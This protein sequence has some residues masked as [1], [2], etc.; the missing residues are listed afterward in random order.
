MKNARA[1]APP[2]L[3]VLRPRAPHLTA[4]ARAPPRGAPGLVSLSR[5]AERARAE[6][7]DPYSSA[8]DAPRDAD[9]V[10]AHCH[11]ACAQNFYSN[12]HSFAAALRWPFSR[13]ARW[14]AASDIEATRFTLETRRTAHAQRR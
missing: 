7:A 9:R 6:R 14:Y 5:R 12:L 1:R 4:R 8:R 2:R 13:G 11:D 3:A 10:H